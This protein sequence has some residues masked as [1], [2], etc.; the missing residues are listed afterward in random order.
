MKRSLGS[1]FGAQLLPE[2]VDHPFHQSRSKAISDSTLVAATTQASTDQPLVSPLQTTPTNQAR[3]DQTLD[4]INLSHQLFLKVNPFDDQN[5][6]AWSIQNF[7]RLS[8]LQRMQDTLSILKQPLI[9]VI[10]PV[11][12]TPEKFLKASI[13]SVIHQVYTNWELCIADDA[14]T[15]PHVRTLLQSYAD[16]DSRIKVVYRSDN[17]H[18]SRCTNSALEVATGEFIAL[19]D[20][21]DLLTPD[22]LYEVA[23]IINKHPAADLVYSDEDK[24]TLHGTLTNPFFKPD[25]CPDSFLSRMYTCH[26]GVYRRS[27]V[28][29]IGGFRVGFE[30]SQ[31]YDFVLRLTEKTNNIFHIPKVLYHWRIHEASCADSA[32]AK[33]YAYEAAQRA[34]E[35]AIQ[36][37]GEPGKVIRS[38]RHPGSYIVRYHIPTF[39]KV[40]IIIPTRNLGVLLNQCLTS[41]FVNS[42]YPNYDVI[43]I[44]NGSTEAD[45]FQV[46][47]LWKQKELGRF[48]CYKL[49]IP[50]N[51]SK[52]NNYAVQKTDA[53]YLLFLNNDTEVITSN[54]IE[55]MVEQAQRSSV[56][57]VGALLLYPDFTIQH[58]GIVLGLGG[59]GCHSHKHFSVQDAGYFNQ[60]HTVNN[61]LAVTGACLMCRREV[62]QAVSGFE[63]ALQV[64]Y[65]DVDFCLKLVE[66]GYKNVYLPHVQ[67]YHHESKSRGQEKT[68]EA[69]QRF[70]RETA[71]MYQKWSHLIAND[72]CYSPH[73]TREAV[74]YSI[75]NP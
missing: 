16:K 49:D 64:A 60:I 62:F 18:I 58:A 33:P 73:L 74:D 27:L 12:N 57:A 2:L 53:E 4:P 28:N 48:Q 40:S 72:P 34:L 11:Y 63:E 17:G 55:G 56:G 13:E 8:D 61:Y 38:L 54:W 23:L 50:F 70:N 65:N 43:V 66:K 41:I 14:S 29:E 7:P 47:E 68:P 75:R 24:L 22:A 59:I 37:R 35:E 36:R 9:S 51:Y 42:S 46:L 21:D 26:L 52:L 3:F 5:Y 69:Q 30:G 20:H 31:D 10:V 19:L 39:K 44:D 32:D 25:W 1:L 71:F 45:L 6:Y 15:A 67:L